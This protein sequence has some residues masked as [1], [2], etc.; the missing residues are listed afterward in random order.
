MSFSTFDITELPEESDDDYAVEFTTK[1]SRIGIAMSE[2]EL[3]GVGK[4]MLQSVDGDM[5]E[6]DGKHASEI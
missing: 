5:E 3:R 6:F 2:D 4:A 1:E